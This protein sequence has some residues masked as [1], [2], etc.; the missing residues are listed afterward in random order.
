MPVIPASGAA[1][2]GW[3]NMSGKR[4]YFDPTSGA[5]YTGKHVI[6]GVTYTFGSNGVLVS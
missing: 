5:M 4:Y 3:A 1:V 2:K 6:N